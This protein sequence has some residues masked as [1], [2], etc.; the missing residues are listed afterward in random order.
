MDR[1]ARPPRGVS[2][3]SIP[4]GSL[5]VPLAKLPGRLPPPAAA[6]GAR[7]AA[8][9]RTR[10]GLARSSLGLALLGLAARPGPAAAHALV[11]DSTPPA[12]ATLAAA[13]PRI[14]LRFNSRIDP[15]RSRLTLVGPS[16]GAAAAAAPL[17]LAPDPAADATRIEAP[18][19]PLEPGAWRLRWQ[20][21]AVDGHITRGD[22]PFTIRP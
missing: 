11:V 21:L 17:A 22:I 19:P 2:F 16:A 6:A 20:V 8:P 5:P 15:E 4:E 14:V 12:G 1:A 7:R 13:P 9:G 3:R 10:R 18:C